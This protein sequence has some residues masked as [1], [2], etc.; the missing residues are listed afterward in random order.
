MP[1]P[2]S[3]R[4]ATSPKGRGFGKEDEL[5]AMPRAL[6]SG[7]LSSAARLRGPSGKALG[8]IR[9]HPGGILTHNGGG[10]RALGCGH[11]AAVGVVAG[12]GQVMLFAR[13]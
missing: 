3:L 4:D 12:I 9:I 1:S 13:L 7:E 8:S 5:Y 6:P 2:S 10:V 11:A